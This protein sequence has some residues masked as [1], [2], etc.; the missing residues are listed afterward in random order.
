MQ[1]QQCRM[2]TH[3]GQFVITWALWHLSQMNQKAR[4]VYVH[5]GLM[6]QVTL[7]VTLQWQ[8][9]Y[10]YSN[11]HA[12]VMTK[13]KKLSRLGTIICLTALTCVKFESFLDSL[14]NFVIVFNGYWSVYFKTT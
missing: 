11:L 12:V 1:K 8:L 14:L 4:Q 10:Q 9:R 3:N 7:N 13:L 2:T 6:Y 5:S